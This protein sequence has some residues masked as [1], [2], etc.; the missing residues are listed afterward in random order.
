[1][2]HDVHMCA[3]VEASI[4]LRNDTVV[5]NS[6]LTNQCIAVA[7]SRAGFDVRYPGTVCFVP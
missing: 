4:L 2:A 7:S 3:K 1:M 5:R 6:K